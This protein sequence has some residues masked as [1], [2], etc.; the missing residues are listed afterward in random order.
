MRKERRARY[1]SGSRQA[2]SKVTHLNLQFIKGISCAR[3][4][5]I[6]QHLT[7]FRSF[8]RMCVQIFLCLLAFTDMPT[9]TGWSQC[10]F[11]ISCT[12]ISTLLYYHLPRRQTITFF[13]FHSGFF[14]IWSM[15]NARNA[16]MLLKKR[17]SETN[18]HQKRAY[19]YKYHTIKMDPHIRECFTTHFSSILA[20]SFMC[21]FIWICVCARVFFFVDSAHHNL[22]V[23]FYKNG[24][25]LPL[26]FIKM[27][28]FFYVK[29]TLALIVKSHI[30]RSTIFFSAA[31][32][33]SVSER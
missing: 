13:F 19:M 9:S 11:A 21:I 14:W 10:I 16:K 33:H 17:K 4:H 6:W 31:G 18:T 25:F 7:L 26:K 27:M 22:T 3:V 24:V 8:V 30:W 23:N 28:R 1:D 15:F 29:R 20:H 32:L 5:F 12:R 2:G